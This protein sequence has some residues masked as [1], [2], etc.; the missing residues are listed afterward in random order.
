MYNLF[1]PEDSREI[2]IVVV[3]C[4]K[5]P[6]TFKTLSWIAENKRPKC[7]ICKVEMHITMAATA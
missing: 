2:E 5:C 1:M 6:R 4:P 3:S 7:P